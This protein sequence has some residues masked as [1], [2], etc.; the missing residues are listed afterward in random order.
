MSQIRKNQMDH[1]K[2]LC[3][4][5]IPR[6]ALQVLSITAP[7]ILRKRRFLQRM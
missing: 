7:K 3:K 1:L 4:E 6:D 5:F 2:Y